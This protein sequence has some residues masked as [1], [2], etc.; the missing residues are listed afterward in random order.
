MNFNSDS[1][2]YFRLDYALVCIINF[3]Y[4]VGWWGEEGGFT[5]RCFLYLFCL[6]IAYLIVV[7]CEVGNILFGHVFGFDTLCI[8]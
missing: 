8:I 5:G 1:L 3:I 2:F 6:F 4:S 7:V